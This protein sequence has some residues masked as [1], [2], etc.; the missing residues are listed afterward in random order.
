MAVQLKNL[1]IDVLFAVKMINSSL[2]LILRS[3][4]FLSECDKNKNHYSLTIHIE[5]NIFNIEC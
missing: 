1:S 5:Y 4:G 2:V 3:H